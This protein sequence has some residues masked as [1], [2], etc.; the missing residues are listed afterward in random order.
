MKKSTKTIIG[1]VVIILLIAG[2]S[3]A[4]YE[5]T[6]SEPVDIAEVNETANEGMEETNIINEVLENE[7]ENTIVNEIANE[8]ANEVAQN[9]VVQ[10]TTTEQNDDENEE[11]VGNGS[12]VVTGTNAT[13][14]ERAVELA[15]EYY[16]E[17]YGSTDGVYFNYDSVNSDGRYIVIA[18]A[19]GS[20]QNRFL[21]VNLNTEE[22]AE[23]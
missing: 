18:G 20:S 21:F 22:V 11:Y 10:N 2:I 8:V 5:A 17:T 1:V 3:F 13:R 19:A 6:K 16:E 4:A 7:V 12:E 23:N 14:E 9:E 15:K